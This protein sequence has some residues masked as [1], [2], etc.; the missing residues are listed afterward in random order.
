MNARGAMVPLSAG[1]CEMWMYKERS[2]E[3]S[4]RGDEGIGG[5]VGLATPFAWT[6][7]CTCVDFRSG[8]FRR[9]AMVGEAG[10]AVEEDCEDRVAWIVVYGS[11]Y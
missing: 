9:A 6:E 1:F 11:A 7:S 5:V 4:V 3:I 8:C 10:G 2:A